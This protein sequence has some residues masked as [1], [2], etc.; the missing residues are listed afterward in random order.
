MAVCSVSF[1]LIYPKISVNLRK[2]A[3]EEFQESNKETNFK[4]CWIF[5][6]QAEQKMIK[7]I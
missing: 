3:K 1:C 2:L 6:K 7:N 4:K 5:L